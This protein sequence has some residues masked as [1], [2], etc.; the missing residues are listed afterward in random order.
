MNENH[1][2][3]G[4][5]KKLMKSVHEYGKKLGCTMATVNTMSFQGAQDFYEKLGYAIDFKRAGY[6]KDSCCLFMR[7]EL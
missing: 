6:N 5:G 7:K 1:R 4:L 3:S 2:K